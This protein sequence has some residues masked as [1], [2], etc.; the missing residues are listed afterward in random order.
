MS[1]EEGQTAPSI[2]NWPTYSFLPFYHGDCL[3]FFF[4]L[5]LPTSPY[6]SLLVLPNITLNIY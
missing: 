4:M 3:G 5:P 1:S 2:C 6:C